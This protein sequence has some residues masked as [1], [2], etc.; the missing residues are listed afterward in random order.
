MAVSYCNLI[1][2]Y[3]VIKCSLFVKPESDPMFL[4]C[5]IIL[6]SIFLFWCSKIIQMQD[7]LDEPLCFIMQFSGSAAIIIASVLT[8]KILLTGLYITVKIREMLT[9]YSWYN[10]PHAL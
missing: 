6:Q 9:I 5:Y 8:F 7:V 10:L 3:K 2:G 4:F 1:N